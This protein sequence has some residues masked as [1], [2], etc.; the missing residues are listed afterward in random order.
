MPKTEKS[1]REMAEKLTKEELLALL[2]GRWFF[3][4]VN[5][6]DILSA[7][8]RVLQKKADGAFKEWNAYNIEEPQNT[9]DGMAAWYGA[10]AEKEVLFKRYERLQTKI[11]KMFHQIDVLRK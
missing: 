6:I 10:M 8:I 2:D 9:F 11:D 1:A 4:N 7:R 3:L 5:P